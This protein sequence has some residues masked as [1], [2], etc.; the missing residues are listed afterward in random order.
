MNKVPMQSHLDQLKIEF[1][2]ALKLKN[3]LSDNV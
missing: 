2:D 3:V 1:N